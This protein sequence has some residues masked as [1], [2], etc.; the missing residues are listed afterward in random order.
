[1]PK[2]FVN[3]KYEIEKLKEKDQLVPSTNIFT[4]QPLIFYFYK[5]FV[6]NKIGPLNFKIQINS[7]EDLN[8]DLRMMYFRDL[9][10]NLYFSSL[11]LPDEQHHDLNIK[12]DQQEKLKF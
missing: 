12:S 10:L 6:K 7:L 2:L 5:I 1:M 9:D 3:C 8:D 11:I 4:L